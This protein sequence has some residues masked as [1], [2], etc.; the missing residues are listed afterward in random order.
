M[1]GEIEVQSGLLLDCI[2]NDI[3][4]LGYKEEKASQVGNDLI[5]KKDVL[6]VLTC[7]S[8]IE[9]YKKVL[10]NDFNNNER[11]LLNEFVKELHDKAYSAKNTAI[12]LNKKKIKFRSGEFLWFFNSGSQINGDENFNQN[13]FTVVEELTYKRNELIDKTGKIFNRRPDLCFFVNGILFAYLEFKFQNNNQTAKKEGRGKVIGD[14]IKAVDNFYLATRTNTSVEDT[15][16][17]R[18]SFLKLF[19]KATHI[20]AFDLHEAYVLRNIQSYFNDIKK[21]SEKDHHSLDEIKDEILKEFRLNPMDEYSKKTN[22]EKMKEILTCLYSKTSIENEILYYNFLKYNIDKLES[23]KQGK[24]VYI[25]KEGRLCSPRPK[26][27]FGVDKVLNRVEELYENE[28]NKD[29]LKNELI[30]KLNTHLTSEQFE[31]EVS[32]FNNMLNN[33]DTYSLL[34][35]YAAGFG[36]TF[37]MCWLAL[38]MKDLFKNNSGVIKKDYLFDKILLVSDRVELRSQVFDSMVDMK[39]DKSLYGEAEKTEDFVKLLNDDSSRI[40]VVNIQKFI[41][42]KNKMNKQQKNDLASKRVAF[43]IDEVHRSNAGDYHKNM[44][45]LFEDLIASLDKKEDIKNLIIGLTATPSDDVLQRFGEIVA[46]SSEGPVCRPLDA[47]TMREAIEE[48]FVLDPTKKIFSEEPTKYFEEIMED[49]KD[50]KRL[51]SDPEL[52]NHPRRIKAIA[53]SVADILVSHT[54]RKIRGQ[55]IGTRGKGMLACNSIQAALK[56]RDELKDALKERIVGTKYEEVY[57]DYKVFVVYTKPNQESPDPKG[58]NDNMNEAKVISEFK[59]AKHGIIIVVDKL[60]TGFD[61]PYLHTLFLDKTVRGINAVQTLCRVNRTTPYKEDCL[62]VDYSLESINRKFIAEAFEKYEGINVA[63]CNPKA[64]LQEIEQTYKDLSIHDVYKRFYKSFF[65]RS[66][67]GDLDLDNK[68]KQYNPELI[69][70]FLKIGANFLSQ[71]NDYYGVVELDKKYLSKAIPLFIKKI[72]D[73]TKTQR[74]KKKKVSVDVEIEDNF[75]I[76][77]DLVDEENKATK[78]TTGEPPQKPKQSERD[79]INEI[80]LKN[81]KELLKED[82]YNEFISNINKLFGLMLKNE[83]KVPYKGFIAGLKSGSL[84]NDEGYND[85]KKLYKYTQRRSKKQFDDFFF[86][87]FEIFIDGSNYN[88]FLN[89]IK[90]E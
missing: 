72:R 52:Y 62:V 69:E 40:I 45:S 71:I 19:E 70:E 26:Q 81:Q 27:K 3:D 75:G 37:I 90:G 73:L 49:E 83:A 24:R 53:N 88:K 18:N 5:I 77:I 50:L 47:F 14:Y 41:S 4:G 58:L 12:F 86:Y 34:L 31:S 2:T 9:T 68:V 66:M 22:V 89:Y 8:N 23:K 84:T 65:D 79:L 39:I 46:I 59:K 17:K 28:S 57:R 55:G 25:G 7:R 32:Q 11:D 13:V 42:I 87:C 67:E 38:R 64:I 80:L 85:F 61:D 1:A 6:S 56:Y 78:K 82:A 16:L 20:T 63:A 10:S 33:K 15:E 51:P 54:F 74:D 48:G 29:F 35:Q 44:K 30:S 76:V 21:E 60:Q 36:K 43:I